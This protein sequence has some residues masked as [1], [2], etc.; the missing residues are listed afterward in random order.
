MHRFF[1]IEARR[2]LPLL[3]L[4]VLL[5][6]LSIYDN[7]FR[8]VEQQVSVP[9]EEVKNVLTFITADRGEL[10]SSAQFMVIESAEQWAALLEEHGGMPDYPFNETYEMAVRAVNGEVKSIQMFPQEDGSVQVQVRVNLEP[11]VYHVVTVE[12]DQVGST[13]RWL[14]LDE[15]DRVLQEVVIAPPEGEDTAVPEEA[16]EETKTE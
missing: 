10:E 11:N 12:R 16:V 9:E 5:V 8:S 6:S 7:F 14:F 4:L 13:S 3:F 1:V 15:E 2:L